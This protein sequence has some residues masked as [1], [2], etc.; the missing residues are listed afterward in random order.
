MALITVLVL[1][2]VESPLPLRQGRSS[3]GASSELVASRLG[4]VSIAGR[5]TSSGFALDVGKGTSNR[6]VMMEI[7]IVA[8][9][10]ISMIAFL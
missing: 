8:V 5:F 7:V 2:V 6:A 3:D 9:L 4:E 10:V 1:L